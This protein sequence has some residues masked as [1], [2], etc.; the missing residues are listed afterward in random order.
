MEPTFDHA[1]AANQASKRRRCVEGGQ[2]KPTSHKGPVE[3]VGV[4]RGQGVVGVVADGAVGA[5][6]GLGRA[7]GSP[8]MRMRRRVLAE[9]HHVAAPAVSQH[10]PAMSKH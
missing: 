3:H 5:Q 7:G 8:M 6:R 1:S 10:V 9:P 4:G 2:C